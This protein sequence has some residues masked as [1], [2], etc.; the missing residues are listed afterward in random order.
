MDSKQAFELY[1]RQAEDITNADYIKRVANLSGPNYRSLETHFYRHIKDIEI[2]EPLIIGKTA[3]EA[4]DF[5]DIKDYFLKVSDKAEEKNIV[6]ENQKI[7]LPELP[8]WLVLLADIHGGGKCNYRQLFDDL[9]LVENTDGIYCGVCGDIT[10]NF[11]IGKLASIQ[12]KQPTT[13]AMEERFAEWFIDKIKS[14]LLFWV[15]GN[16]DNW[17][18][19]L[20]GRDIYKI[21]LK[22]VNCLYDRQQIVFDLIKGNFSERVLIRHKYKWKST[23]NISHG[24]EVSWD[25]GD[26]NYDIV[27]GG[28]YHQAT[29]FREF[30]KQGK[31]RLAIVMGTYKIKDEYA[32]ELG[33][34][35]SYGTG[36]CMLVYDKNYNRY[37]FDLY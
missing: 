4:T 33:V 13:F 9:E 2:K 28:H 24:Q 29:L 1:P 35:K 23:F 3:Y 8:C 10:D 16:H 36:S 30:I 21:Y 19:K 37:Q 31:K 6:E 18:Y 15:S 7:Y 26:I 20:C 34:P 11:I 22:D 14:K 12:N 5:G 17:T 32:E 27:I 25:R